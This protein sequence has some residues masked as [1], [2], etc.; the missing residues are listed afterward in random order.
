GGVQRG[1]AI[2]IPKNRQIDNGREEEDQ[3]AGPPHLLR[4]IAPVGVP[5]LAIMDMA[6]QGMELFPLQ[7]PP[8]HP[9]PERWI[10]EIVEDED[11][12]IEAPQLAYGPVEMVARPTG[13][14]ALEGNGRRR[15]TGRK[16]GEELSHLIP[17]GRDPVEMQS[18]FAG[19]QECGEG[20]IVPVGIQPVDPLP[21]E[22]PDARTEALAKHRESRKI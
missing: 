20:T 9:A 22:P 15:V 12:L 7:Q 3:T 5:A 2:V 13:Q 19:A 1:K 10:G 8:P 6:R 18:P 4:E 21:V 14:Q 17:V 11:R 16:G